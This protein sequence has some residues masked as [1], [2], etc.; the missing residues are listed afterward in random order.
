MKHN[1]LF[2][3]RGM[4]AVAGFRQ[5]MPV[6]PPVTTGI[7][8][9]PSR[10]ETSIDEVRARIDRIIVESTQVLSHLTFV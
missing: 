1:G 7:R 6:T 8:S 10:E 5:S 9:Q 2:P 4:L 3:R